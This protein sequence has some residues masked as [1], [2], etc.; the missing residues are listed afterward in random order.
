MQNLIFC[1][2]SVKHLRWGH[3]AKIANIYYSTNTQKQTMEPLETLPSY[4]CAK[5]NGLYSDF[6]KQLKY[7]IIFQFNHSTW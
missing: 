7:S 6:V 4:D 2:V 5:M 1:A 3:L